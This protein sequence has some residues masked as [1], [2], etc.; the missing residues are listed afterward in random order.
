MIEV[1][2][3]DEYKAELSDE[4]ILWFLLH[5]DNIEIVKEE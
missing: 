5:T 4:A 3:G 1:T 2:S